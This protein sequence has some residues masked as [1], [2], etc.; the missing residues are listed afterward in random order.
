MDLICRESI[1]YT[2][3]KFCNGDENLIEIARLIKL[4]GR[5]DLW[6]TRAARALFISFVV[7]GILFSIIVNIP[8]LFI[9]WSGK[10]LLSVLGSKKLINLLKLYFQ[11]SVRVVLK[12]LQNFMNHLLKLKKKKQF[13]KQ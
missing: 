6:V 10:S 12:I 2:R 8:L 1:V 7:I 9:Y 5:E 3:Y 13:F 4:L 11:N